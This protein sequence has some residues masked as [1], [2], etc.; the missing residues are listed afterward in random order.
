MSKRVIVV[1]ADKPFQ[2]RLIAGAMAAGGA[3][4]AFASA[5]ELPGRIECDL[6][7]YAMG[8]SIADP[9][10]V[11]LLARLPDGAWMVPILPAPQLA[12]MVT[13]LAHPRVA[14]VLVAEEMDAQSVSGTVSKRLYGDLFGLE[15]V[16]PW[17][18][19]LYSM[20]V[21]DYQEK[22]LAI[23]AI[24]DFASAMGVRRKYR[25]QI[26]QCIDEMLMNALY[27]APIDAEGKPLFAEV[28][29]RERVGLK[30]HEKAMVQ[31]ACD[32]ERFAVSVR[33]AFGS[34]SKKTVLAYLE[35][36]LHAS[37]AEQIDRKAGGAGLGLYLIANSATEIYFHIFSCTATEV[38]CTFDLSSARSQLRAFGVFEQSVET[39]ARPPSGP[40]RAL[41]TVHGRRRE[42]LAPPPR[43]SPLLPVMMT[44]SVL[45]LI[46]A[47]ALAALPYVHHPAQA[48]L[49]IE[50]DPPGATVFVDGRKR[51]TAPLS[52]EGL[53]AGV[54]YAVRSTL[55]GFKDDDELVTAADGESAVKLKLAALLGAVAIESDPPGAHLIVDGNDTGKLTPAEL[56]LASGK[57]AEVTLR[58]DGFNQER[59]EVS[60]PRAGE[61]EVYRARLPLSREVAALTINAT[62]PGATVTV[63]G[64][65]LMPPRPSYDTFVK[66]KALHHV[67]VSLPGYID[68]RADLSLDGGEHRT[69]TAALRE[70]GVLALDTNCKARVLVDGKAVGTAPLAPL[71]LAEGEH[72]LALRG[73]RPFLRFQ[74]RVTVEKGKTLA[75][76]LDFGTVQIAAAG[77]TAHPEGAGDA[78]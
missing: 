16:M 33:D 64:M 14:T 73:E 21:G 48:T 68:F 40:A 57:T 70:G 71:A 75:E 63:D 8:W 12:G 3:V 19:R 17:G 60:G 45:L 11:S 66:P 29:V 5:D 37:G 65:A 31:Y 51:G 53:Q 15:K 58:K 72:T 36:C 41:A 18:V 55:A 47:V 24:G 13:L 50:T 42:D 54:S 67:K 78:G 25:E 76:K 23:S 6:V 77:V 62:P 2:K 30:V 32:G 74:T 49:R 46:V 22:A 56:S 38:V 4:Q 34:L 43:A 26:D 20:L 1:A 28:P 27:D 69:L 10:Y 52:V 44:F 39:A 7:L 59:L 35:K 9:Q 61:R